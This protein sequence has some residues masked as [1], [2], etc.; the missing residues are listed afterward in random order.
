[1]LVSVNQSKAC[2]FLHS[3]SSAISPIP[4]QK[5]NSGVCGQG[6]FLSLCD[7]LIILVSV[8]LCIFIDIDT[9]QC[10][11]T[12][13]IYVSDTSGHEWNYNTTKHWDTICNSGK[14]QSPIGKVHF[15]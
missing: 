6:L 14:M 10:V 2:I 13:D 9:S 3:Q 7:C 11:F 5:R 8:F 12:N 15:I 4:F 1:M